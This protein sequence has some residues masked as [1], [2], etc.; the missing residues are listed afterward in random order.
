MAKVEDISSPR[1]VE[2]AKEYLRRGIALTPVEMRGKKPTSNAWQKNYIVGEENARKFEGHNV[3]FILGSPSDWLVDID[4]DCIEAISLAEYFLPKTGWV[5]GHKSARRSHYMYQCEDAK[6]T[7]FAG[8]DGMVVE[9]RSSGGMT[10]APGSIHPSNEPIIFSGI[11][12]KSAGATKVDLPNLER[13]VGDLAAASLILRHGWSGGKGARDEI[14]VALCGVMLRA[15]RETEQIDRLLESVAKAGGDEELG[16]RLKAEAQARRLSAGERV[17][18]V[19]SLVK[20]LGKDVTTRVLDWLGV[21]DV[22]TVM[23]LNLEIAFVVISGKARVIHDGGKWSKDDPEFLSVPDARNLMA[24]KGTVKAGKKTISAFDHW[25]ASRERRE[26]RELVFKPNG[27]D[28]RDYNLWRGWPVASDAR[29][30]KG[31]KVFLKHVR[32]NIC[33]GDENLYD[34]TMTWL[35]DAV[36]NPTVRPSVALV[37][38]G[39][40]GNGKSMFAEYVLDMFGKYGVV[41]TNQDHLFSKFNGHL[42]H[43]LMVFADESCWAGNRHHESVLKN[44]ISGEKLSIEPKGVGTYVLDNYIRLMMATNNAWAIP[45][46]HSARR[47]FILRMADDL[48]SREFFTLLAAERKAGGPQCLLSYL[49]D[50]K[51][52]RNLK[53][54]PKTQAL[55]DNKLITMAEEHPIAS[56]W[57]H[58][59]QEGK[60]TRGADGWAKEIE[61]E[62]LYRD[63]LGRSGGAVDRSTQV[64]FGMSFR[65]LVP[66]LIKRRASRSDEKVSVRSEKV[67][68]RRLRFNVYEVK[69][70]AECRQHFMKNILQVDDYDW[71]DLGNH[72]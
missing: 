64:T 14:A 56:W 51:I 50:W 70:L 40:E 2:F 38:Q 31:C 72:D 5:F 46:G 32:E 7:K 35:A 69:S 33:S 29:G 61:P 19:P 6:T 17:P 30:E 25:L 27:C 65:R 58:R 47:Y 23:G 1:A 3:G 11:D 13:C 24:G 55:L 20:L 4:L 49:R 41:S 59:L 48:A 57:M 39:D 21:H 52:E 8:E 18:G 15:G 68:T 12:W 22:G 42:S 66:K 63:Y 53:D 10:V 26:Y 28:E 45:V 67:M 16:M 37:M 71:D 43:K 9:I 34:Y 36:Q 44:I 62:R 54:I 60:I